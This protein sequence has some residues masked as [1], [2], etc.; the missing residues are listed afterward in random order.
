MKI[1][2]AA[3]EKLQAERDALK[4]AN[5]E[6]EKEVER[7]NDVIARVHAR[8]LAQLCKDIEDEAKQ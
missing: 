3:C 8:A 4:A 7:L 6:L 5:A 2:V 1:L